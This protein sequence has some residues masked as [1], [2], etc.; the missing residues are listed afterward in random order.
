MVDVPEKKQPG[1]ESN[2]ADQGEKGQ[3][4]P[5]FQPRKKEGGASMPCSGK[6][7]EGPVALPCSPWK[8]KKRGTGERA[9]SLLAQG[10]E[11]SGGRDSRFH[12]EN[13]TS[14]KGDG[15]GRV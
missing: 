1:V 2:A 5:L 11:E 14:P 4:A 12:S 13:M 3:Q 15:G 8:K 7:G 10:G 9:S 6:G